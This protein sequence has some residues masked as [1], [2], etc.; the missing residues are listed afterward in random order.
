[1]KKSKKIIKRLNSFG[2]AGV[3]FVF[4]IDFE[5]KN[6]L[7]FHPNENRDLLWQTPNHSNF[8]QNKKLQVRTSG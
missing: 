4:L 6:P 2:K 7:I 3:P 1:M 8:K 5:G